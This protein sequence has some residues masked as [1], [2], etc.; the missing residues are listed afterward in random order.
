MSP[1]AAS[2]PGGV[3][4]PRHK[5]TVAGAVSGPWASATQG[6]C[7]Q[8]AVSAAL[9]HSRQASDDIPTL[10]FG[11]RNS[12]FSIQ[13]EI[14]SKKKNLDMYG[15]QTSGHR[16][17]GSVPSLDLSRLPPVRLFPGESLCVG[18][19]SEVLANEHPTLGLAF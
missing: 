14:T 2:E 1:G 3:S 17:T 15:P 5:G 13:A 19:Q 16:G 8:G 4:R 10:T 11:S 6:P 7:A 9:T 18:G 12:R